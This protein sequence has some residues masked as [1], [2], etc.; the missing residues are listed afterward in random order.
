MLAEILEMEVRE[1]VTNDTTNA[2][3]SKD[4]E[5][6]VNTDEV[7]EFGGIITGECTDNA[8]DDSGP[9]RNVAAGR[10]DGNE[11]S[12]GTRAPTNGTPLAI[13]TVVNNH[14]CKPT[15]RSRKIGNNAGHSRSEIATE[16]T[17]T[18]ESEPT[19]PEENG[20][21]DDVG[22]IVWSVVEFVSSMTTALAQHDRVGKGSGTR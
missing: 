14:P 19:E 20:S 4:I 7:L 6:I 13:E 5:G 3:D 22:D 1:Q 12:D 15:H 10:S 2:V 17:T 16:C 8:K 11:T 9:G 21:E 18:V